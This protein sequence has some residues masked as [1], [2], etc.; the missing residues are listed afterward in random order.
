VTDYSLCVGTGDTAHEIHCRL[1]RAHL[2]QP[3]EKTW[4]NPVTSIGLTR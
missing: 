1:G 2:T 4:K 3:A